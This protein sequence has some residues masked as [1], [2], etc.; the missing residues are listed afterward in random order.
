MLPDLSAEARHDLRAIIAYGVEN[1]GH[2]ATRRYVVRLPD[3]FETI[4]SFPGIARLRPEL[5]ADTRAFPVGSHV[6]IYE[7]RAD[8]ILILRVR[9]GREDWLNDSP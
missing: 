2:D 1:F 8:A 5:G 6:V 9:H 3:V 7:V 4:V